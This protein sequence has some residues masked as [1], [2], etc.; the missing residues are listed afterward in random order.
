MEDSTEKDK[1][2][3]YP[4]HKQEDMNCNFCYCP[5]YNQK[6]CGGNYKILPDGV[7]DCSE[8][9]VVHDPI[10]GTQF[11]VDRLKN[12]FREFVEKAEKGEV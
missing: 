3:Y 8:C 2:V 12:G 4:C 6:D 9:I 1:C 5:L 7:K 11:V 10:E